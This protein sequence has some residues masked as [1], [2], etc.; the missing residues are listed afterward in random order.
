MLQNEHME[1]R[2]NFNQREEKTSF[3]SSEKFAIGFMAMDRLLT[4][5]SSERVAK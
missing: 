4:L 5:T 2:V 3:Y 1:L